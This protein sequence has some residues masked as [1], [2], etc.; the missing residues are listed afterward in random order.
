DPLFRLDDCCQLAAGLV[1]EHVDVR[2]RV[3]SLLGVRSDLAGSAQPL[4]RGRP[5]VEAIS[6]REWKLPSEPVDAL[7]VAQNDA[8]VPVGAVVDLVAAPTRAEE[9]HPDDVVAR[10]ADFEQF[11]ERHLRIMSRSS[12]RCSSGPVCKSDFRSEERGPTVVACTHGFARLWFAPSSR[13]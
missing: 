11:F 8:N 2:G 7:V 13:A 6:V 5:D 3:A 1:D 9:I 12:S 10:A 4:E